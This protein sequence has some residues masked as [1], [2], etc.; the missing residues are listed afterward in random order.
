MAERI[1]T[2]PILQPIN[3]MNNGSV[4]SPTGVGGGVDNANNTG[5][6]SGFK[7]DIFCNFGRF[8]NG[9]DYVDISATD[10]H[11][12][13]F[14]SGTSGWR[15]TYAGELEAETGYFR[16]DITGASGTFSGSLTVGTSPNWFRTDADGN[17]WWGGAT[18]A[19]APASITNAG[20]G[21]F[22]SITITGGTVGG[23][24]TSATSFVFGTGANTVGLDSGGTNPAIYAGSATPGSAP[25]MVTKA[26]A[27]TATSATITGAI[28]ATSGT[29]GSFTIGT[30]L[31]TGSKT[32]YNDTN[33]GVHLGSD[34]IGIGN[35][36]FTVS[37]AGVLNAVS[38]TV[39]GCALAT[40]SIGSTTFTSGPLGTGW[41]ISNTGTA[42]FQDI[43]ARGVFRTSVFEKDTISAVNGMVLVSSADVLEADMTASDSSGLVIK[44]ETTFSANEVVRI[45]DG[46]DDEWM[47]VND[48]NVIL[49]SYSESNKNGNSG[50]Y[51]GSQNSQGQ[52][53][54]NTNS[55][56]LTKCKFYLNSFSSPT[57]N[58]TATI[59][60]HSG[61]FGVDGV[62]T[63]PVLATSDPVDVSGISGSFELVEFTFSGANQIALSANTNYFLILNYSNGDAF[64]S[65]IGFG[66]D[67][68]S[69]SADGNSAILTGVNWAVQDTQDYCF[70]IYGSLP[71]GSYSVTRDLAGS[72]GA[73]ANPAWTKGTAVVSMGVG[74]GTKTGYVLMDS[75][76]S[77]SP[78]ID[79]YGRNSNT[80]TD[81]TLHGRFGWLK[82][83]TDADV[84]LAST[85]VWGLY[86]DNAYIKGTIVATS[87]KFGNWTI[88]GN[89]FSTSLNNIF[90]GASAG[91]AITDG[92]YNICVGYWAGKALTEGDGNVFIGQQA[93]SATTAQGGNVFIGQSSGAN[94]ITGYS[95]VYLG[96]AAGGNNTDGIGNTFVGASSGIG[97]LSGDY[98]IFIGN[99]AG[100]YET[101]NNKLFIDSLG[102]ASEVDARVKAL[103][104]GVFA[105][106]TAAQTLTFNSNVGILTST[107]GANSDAVLGIA[108][109]TAPVAHVDNEIQIYSV[110]SSDSTATLGLMLEQAVEDIGTFTATKKIKVKINGVEYW[111]E[112]DPV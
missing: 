3:T 61:T 24:T 92:E 22:S 111:L 104:Y 20:A 36:L 12:A 25:F 75:S 46:T 94:N 66:L 4:F 105:S 31:Y 103:I 48:S 86:T 51:L 108:N 29:I 53:F 57:G 2:F 87:G 54:H 93:G 98:N 85:D 80:Y 45:K 13:N 99:G 28:T 81:V 88:S 59:Y 5:M 70:Y 83:I 67:N 18:L 76:S 32:A 62:P 77:N 58:A 101:G 96:S 39:G 65:G 52:S 7:G 30:Y 60:A 74:T 38:G 1:E 17:S 10:M 84:G 68:S 55:I 35:N 43:T 112:L 21:T 56:K 42:E 82:G 73:N 72:Y 79:V 50:F 40:T 95:N 33:A 19:T 23:W 97:N 100:Y 14:V 47:L 64:G 15:L 27:L 102:R 49:D 109:G 26:G 89:S 16:G 71:T 11:S 110:D 9:N 91:S 37:G 78:Y 90:V 8:G 41:N 6:Y 69:P 63:G 34:G 107:F 106:T 44:G